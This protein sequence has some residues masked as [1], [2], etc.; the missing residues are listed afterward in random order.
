MNS[1]CLSIDPLSCLLQGVDLGPVLSDVFFKDL[2]DGMERNHSTVVIDTPGEAASMVG[3]RAALHEDL[4]V[5][6]E[7]AVIETL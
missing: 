4:N 3:C 2:P 5:L 6:E 7:W 1:T